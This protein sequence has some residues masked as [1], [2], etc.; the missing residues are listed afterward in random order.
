MPMV[1]GKS[2]GVSGQACA[3]QTIQLIM[4]ST[5]S[6]KTLAEALLRQGNLQS[7]DVE[8]VEMSFGDMG[9]AFGNGAIDVAVWRPMLDTGQ[10]KEAILAVL[11][12]YTPIKDTALLARASLPVISPDDSVDLA[13]IRNQT[14][15]A[16]ERGY[17]THQP[18][19]DIVVDSRFVERAAQSEGP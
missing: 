10:D 16:H 19:A 11:A 9:A 5:T 2:C 1:S 3:C 17:I 14:A 13:N 7:T 12:K 4:P 8:Y 18:S 6:P 15:W